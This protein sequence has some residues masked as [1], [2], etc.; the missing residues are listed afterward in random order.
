MQRTR[1]KYPLFVCRFQNWKLV[2]AEQRP[3]ASTSGKTRSCN[4]AFPSPLT[5]GPSRSSERTK[6][7]SAT[8]SGGRNDCSFWSRRKPSWR[9]GHPASRTSRRVRSPR[10]SAW[11]RSWTSSK[12]APATSGQCGNRYAASER[13]ADPRLRLEVIHWISFDNWHADRWGNLRLAN[14]SCR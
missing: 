3:T 7:G 11:T 9:T 12:A 8:S 10:L 14:S 1:Y 13:Y 4:S 5:C 6:N 2:F